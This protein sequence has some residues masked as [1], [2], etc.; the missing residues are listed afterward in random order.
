MRVFFAILAI[1]GAAAK[2]VNDYVINLDLE[3]EVRYAGLFDIPNTSFNDTV[4]KFYSDYFKDDPALT[5]VLYGISSKRGAEND[6]QQRE[7]NGLAEMS[8]L[9]INCVCSPRLTE[10]TK[11]HTRHGCLILALILSAPGCPLS[12]CSRSRCSTKSKP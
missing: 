6:E 5:S 10:S 1:S 4:W 8:R 11:H 2:A 12:S 3:P 9:K 7:I